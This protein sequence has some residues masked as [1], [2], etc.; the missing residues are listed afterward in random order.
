[1]VCGGGVAAYLLQQNRAMPITPGDGALAGLL[2]GVV[3]ALVYLL[4]SIP[5]T[6]LVAPLERAMMERIVQN[7]AGLPPEFREYVGSYLGSAIQVVVGFGF[8]LVIGSMFSTIG[9]VIGALLF[10]KSLP[11]APDNATQAG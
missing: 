7:T 5:I 1:V 11:S 3:G 10:K 4:L 2:A 8:M 6:I 9:G